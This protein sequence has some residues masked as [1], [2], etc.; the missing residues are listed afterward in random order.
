VDLNDPELNLTGYNLDSVTY[1]TVDV[2]DGDTIEDPTQTQG[3]CYEGTAVQPT[4]QTFG[5]TDYNA[6]WGMAGRCPYN[7]TITGASTTITYD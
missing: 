2:D 3:Y 6:D 7:C 4:S 5:A 1:T